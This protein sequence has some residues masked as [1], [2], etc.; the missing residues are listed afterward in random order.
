MPTEDIVL[1]EA[2]NVLKRDFIERCKHKEDDMAKA[3]GMDFNDDPEDLIAILRKGHEM[4]E[5]GNNT[6]EAFMYLLKQSK[7]LNEFTLR[8]YQLTRLIEI[9]K[10]AKRQT[11]EFIS[12][13]QFIRRLGGGF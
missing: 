1:R 13:E 10:H 12:I 6:S 4:N 11:S 5:T 8:V 7:S 3:M 2:F 9:I